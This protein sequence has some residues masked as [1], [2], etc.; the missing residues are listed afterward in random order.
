[1]KLE[2]H[3][4][5]WALGVATVAAFAMPFAAQAQEKVIKIGVLYDYTGPLAG[6]GG[7]AGGHGTQIAIDMINE[8]GGVEGYKIVAIN[9]DAQRPPP[10]MLFELHE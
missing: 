1:M 3:V 7:V 4:R 2:K 9:G 5:R 6:A 8:R 10:D